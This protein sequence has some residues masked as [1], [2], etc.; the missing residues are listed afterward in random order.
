MRKI[1]R[2]AR[3]YGRLLVLREADNNVWIC[4]CE[5]G[6]V[7]SVPD[8][9]IWNEA[10][11]PC[12]YMTRGHV[13]C[14]IQPQS[15]SKK[16]NETEYGIWSGM[17]TRCYNPNH[18][19]FRY[20]G[21]RGIEVCERWRDDFLAFLGDMGKRPHPKYSIDRIDS[22]GPYSPENCRWASPVLQGNN[23][24]K[25]KGKKNH[26]EAWCYEI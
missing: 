26:S 7:I 23:R 1:S 5:C 18:S 19:D 8:K 12:E 2:V 13:L 6:N 22:N 20:Y 15:I 17:K 25:R 16:D 10:T 3:V 11:K 4:Q 21:A 9:E 24:K 14:G